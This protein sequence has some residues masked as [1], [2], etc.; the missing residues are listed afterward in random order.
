MATTNT[1]AYSLLASMA[2]LY[3]RYYYSYTYYALLSILYI[4]D[5][6]LDTMVVV[7]VLAM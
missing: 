7:V 4:E 3:S 6:G 5:S 2:K 1:I